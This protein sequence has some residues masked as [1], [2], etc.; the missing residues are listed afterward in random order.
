MT[1]FSSRPQSNC[2]RYPGMKN[3]SIDIAL[4]QTDIAHF[5]VMDRPYGIYPS[6]AMPVF[7]CITPAASTAVAIIPCSTLGKTT[8]ININNVS[9]LYMLKVKQLIFKFS[10]SYRER[11]HSCLSLSF[12]FDCILK[13]CLRKSKL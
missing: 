6:P 12:S 4:K 11:R 5:K 3:I 1:V 8:F 7:A 9:F 10:P 13:T 2:L